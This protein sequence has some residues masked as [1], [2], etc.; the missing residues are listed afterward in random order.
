MKE[1]RVII[2][3]SVIVVALAILLGVAN[4]MGREDL[5]FTNNKE[6]GFATVNYKEL[7]P[8]CQ[9]AIYQETDKDASKLQYGAIDLSFVELDGEMFVQNW[10]E[11]EIFNKLTRG[12]KIYYQWDG[13]GI[14]VGDSP[15][16]R[17]NYRVVK[18]SLPSDIKDNKNKDKKE[19]KKSDKQT[20]KATKEQ[21][22]KK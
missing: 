5:K 12:L 11:K 8:N 22:N 1:K 19:V 20:D 3:V 18:I 10:N 17:K 6:Y 15:F 9:G 21:P 16:S 7:K 14:R 2:I 13:Q 4:H